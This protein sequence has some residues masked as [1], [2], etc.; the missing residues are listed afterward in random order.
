MA[1]SYRSFLD[2]NDESSIQVQN[3]DQANVS[4]FACRMGR[5]EIGYGDKIQEARG[6][7]G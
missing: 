3:R 6:L 4:T 5:F 2:H 7:V 1:T